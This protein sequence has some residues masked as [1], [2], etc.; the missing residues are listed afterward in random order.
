[1]RT[2]ASRRP[3][4]RSE[5]GAWWLTRTA[6]A[7]RT[8]EMSSGGGGSA[9]RVRAR[10]RSRGGRGPGPSVAKTP[11]D[12]G[13]GR[14]RSDLEAER[15]DGDPGQTPDHAEGGQGPK[16]DTILKKSLNQM[17]I[18][19]LCTKLHCLKPIST[20]KSNVKIFR[21]RMFNIRC[22]IPIT[23][24]RLDVIMILYIN[25]VPVLSCFNILCSVMA[26]LF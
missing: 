17:L 13:A 19:L 22:C 10:S 9:A 20:Q 15:E 1:M 23:K 18:M 14:G 11:A 4:A 16:R 25:Y 3:P 7:A 2:R 5:A 6:T 24:S 8:I 26:V 21:S 12:L